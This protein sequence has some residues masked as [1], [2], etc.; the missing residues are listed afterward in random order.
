M[1]M[2]VRHLPVTA[3]IG[4]SM[5]ANILSGDQSLPLFFP[6]TNASILQGRSDVGIAKV[7]GYIHGEFVTGDVRLRRI[8]HY[9][10]DTGQWTGVKQTPPPPPKLSTVS[11]VRSRIVSECPCA[12]NIFLTRMVT[13]M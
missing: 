13:S 4:P 7:H 10:P 1:H 8:A 9:H 2:V 11:Q 3:P 12:F 6:D 5:I